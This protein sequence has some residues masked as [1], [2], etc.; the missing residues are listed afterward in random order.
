M[1]DDHPT[2]SMTATSRA[3][4]LGTQKLQLRFSMSIAK[5]KRIAGG[6]ER[7][8]RS[9]TAYRVWREPWHARLDCGPG[10]GRFGRL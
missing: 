6:G 8:R 5:G 9:G 2:G 7:L 4:V 1:G 3:S 10:K